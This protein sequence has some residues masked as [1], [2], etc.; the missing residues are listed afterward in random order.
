MEIICQT[1][2]GLFAASG[3]VGMA[4]V[5]DFGSEGVQGGVLALWLS[6]NELLFAVEYAIDSSVT[7]HRRRYAQATQTDPE[8]TIC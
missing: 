5:R 2:S 7:R 1:L 4:W 3:P 6:H 8:S